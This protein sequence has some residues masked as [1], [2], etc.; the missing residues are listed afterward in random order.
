M[1][2]FTGISKLNLLIYSWFLCGQ[3]HNYCDPLPLYYLFSCIRSTS[4]FIN[5]LI[6]RSLVPLRILSHK[7]EARGIFEGARVIRGLDFDASWDK[8]DGVHII[9]IIYT[10]GPNLYSW[11]AAS[12]C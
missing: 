11:F 6:L 3:S 9:I 8:Q 10:K 5:D 4:L 7:E 1:A 12:T 2:Y